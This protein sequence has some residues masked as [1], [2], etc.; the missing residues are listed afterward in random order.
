[1]TDQPRT[2][3]ELYDRIRESSRDEVIL[4]EM[5]RLGFWPNTDGVPNDPATEIRRVG[6]IQRELQ[7]LR[8]QNTQLHN[9]AALQKQMLQERMAET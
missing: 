3:Q 8:A 6:E 9:E 4:E 2:R 7:E 5:I 1:M